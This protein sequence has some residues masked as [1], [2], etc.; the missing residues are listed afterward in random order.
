M[1]FLFIRTCNSDFST[2]DEGAEYGSNEDALA[3][4]VQSAVAIATD[5]IHRGEKTAAVDVCIEDQSGKAVLRTVIAIS[6]SPLMIAAAS[7]RSQLSSS[8]DQANH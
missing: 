1:P 7:H 3:M 5:E 8:E 4:G 2:I 6:V